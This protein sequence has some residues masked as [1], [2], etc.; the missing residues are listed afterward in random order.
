MFAK[1]MQNVDKRG[2]SSS[3]AYQHGSNV[4][5]LSS[6]LGTGSR[7]LFVSKTPNDVK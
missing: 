6:N 4:D 3:L 7:D 2:H 1:K 5:I